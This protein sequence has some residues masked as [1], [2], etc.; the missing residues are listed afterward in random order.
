LPKDLSGILIWVSRRPADE[1]AV[2]LAEGMVDADRVVDLLLVLRHEPVEPG[3]IKA[4]AEAEIVR[5]LGP[6]TIACRPVLMSSKVRFRC[7][8]QRLTCV[9]LFNSHITSSQSRLLI[10]GW[11]R[12]ISPRGSHRS[13]REPLDSSGS[14]HPRK[15]TV[16]H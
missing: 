8:S 4:V 10:A 1:Y 14:C 13:G 3:N 12:G 11:P 9:R 15:T 2:V 16:F 6:F 7:F 5:I